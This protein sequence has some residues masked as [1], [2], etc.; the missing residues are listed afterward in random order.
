MR[1]WLRS[2]E[3]ATPTR[4]AGRGMTHHDV[5]IIGGGNAGISLAARLLRDGATDVAVADG[6]SVHRYRPLLNYVGGGQARMRAVERPMHAVVPKGCTWVE[7]DVVAVDPEAATVRTRGG[8]T[9]G[10]GQLVVCPGMVEDW[11]ATP[12]LA[13]AY[14]EGWAGSTFV[15]SSAPSVW[16]ALTAV[17]S[18]AVAFSVPPEPAPCAATALKPLFLACDHWRRQGCLDDIT[19]H[20]VLPEAGVTGQEKPDARLV[21]ALAAYDVDVLTEARVTELDADARSVTVATPE[22]GRTLGGLAFAHVVPRYRAGGWVAASGLADGSP[23]GLVDIDAET[24]R[25]RRYPSVW[26]IGDAAAVGTRPS[27][28]ALRRQ[29]DVLA[30]NLAAARNGGELRTYDGYTV[31]P[32]TTSRRA[33]MLVEVDR[34]GRPRPS[35]PF[36]DLAKPRLVTWLADR[37]GL[38]VVYWR[39]L[40]RGKV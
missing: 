36:P 38:P 3:D 14:V 28:G 9:L 29:V 15:A 33:L 27:G 37:Y 17:R 2:H 30:D 39:R 23:A 21:R 24:L 22:G 20:L 10:Y 18:G 31:M 19:V 13:A 32:I 16:P 5:L 4:E 34:S 25:H 35:V 12:G 7:D 1:R 8:R 40:L 11:E 26:A 6:R